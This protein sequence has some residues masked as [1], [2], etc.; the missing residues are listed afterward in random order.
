MK[1]LLVLLQYP[2]L[3]LLFYFGSDIE[4]C[5]PQLQNLVLEKVPRLLC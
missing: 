1:M 5:A 2:V 3:L 4:V